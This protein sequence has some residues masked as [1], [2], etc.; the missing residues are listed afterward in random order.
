M[1]LAETWCESENW[2]QLAQDRAQCWA[3]VN[4]AMNL[5]S[6]KCR[7]HFFFKACLPLLS[8]LLLSSRIC[9]AICATFNY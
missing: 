8:C 4:I 3:I 6:H 7:Q 5:L 9:T 2:I 1:D